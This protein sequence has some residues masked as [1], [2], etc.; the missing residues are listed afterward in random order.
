MSGETASQIIEMVKNFLQKHELLS[1][2]FGLDMV[3]ALPRRYGGVWHIATGD[4][5][6][7]ASHFGFL[8]FEFGSYKRRVVIFNTSRNHSNLG[9]KSFS[10]DSASSAFGF[11]DLAEE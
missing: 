11:A 8:K 5:A 2:E 3:K 1:T 4:F 10:D 6:Y 7:Q 9:T